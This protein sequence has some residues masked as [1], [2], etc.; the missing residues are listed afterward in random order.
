[1]PLGV[2][3]SLAL[4]ERGQPQADR[5]RDR[6]AARQRSRAGAGGR[7]LH[8]APRPPRHERRTPSR[9]RTR[10]TTAPSTTLA[11]WPRCWR[12]PKAMTRAARSAPQRSICS[13]RW[14]PRS[15]ACWARSTSP[16]TRRCP[17]GRMAANIN[18]DGINICGPHA[19]PHHDRPRQV[20]PRRLDPRPRRGAGPH[21]ACPTSSPT[22]GFFYRSDQFNLAKHRRARRL[23]RRRHRRDRQ[24]RGL[25]QGAAGE[26][27]G[28]GLPPALR[29]AARRTGTSRARWR[30]RSSS[31]TSGVEGRERAAH[32]GLEAG[33]R[34]RGR[35]SRTCSSTSTSARRSRTTRSCRRG[36]RATSSRARAR[37]PSPNSK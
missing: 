5:E 25:G 12:S 19:R 21:G 6:P 23:L 11:A 26:V 8:R 35:A 28:E 4:A 13:R 9:A 30:T 18:I 29:R 36:T 20:E 37:R 16:R 31:S 33:R 32:A 2:T 24:A 14:R 17:P 10:S 15:R 3:L 27:R 22:A 1:M 7:R 34:V